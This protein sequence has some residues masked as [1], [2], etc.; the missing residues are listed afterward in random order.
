MSLT[1]RLQF[2]VGLLHD[3]EI[4]VVS[5][6]LRPLLHALQ[7]LWFDLLMGVLQRVLVSTILKKSVRRAHPVVRETKKSISET[8]RREFAVYLR[9]TILS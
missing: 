7:N 5:E 9:A 3:S 8:S 1:L 4:R 6:H 2:H